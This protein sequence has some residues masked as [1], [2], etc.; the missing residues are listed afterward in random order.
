VTETRARLWHPAPVIPSATTNAADHA[1]VAHRG[2]DR[3]K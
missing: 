2:A 1:I 3:A